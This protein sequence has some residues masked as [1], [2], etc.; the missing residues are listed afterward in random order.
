MMVLIVVI[1][2]LVR[3]VIIVNIVCVYISLS[4][5]IYIYIYIHMYRERQRD[6]IEREMYL[7]GSTDLSRLGLRPREVIEATPQNWKSTVTPYML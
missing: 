1:V 3:E 6:I 7:F 4:L 2:I 5:Y